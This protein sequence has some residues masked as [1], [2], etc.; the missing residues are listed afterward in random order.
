MIN[1]TKVLKRQLMHWV[2]AFM[3]KIML[4]W[5]RKCMWLLKQPLSL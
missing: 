3:T 1:Q 4:W 2:Q 5:Q